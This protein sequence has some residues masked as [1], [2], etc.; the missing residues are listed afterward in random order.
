LPSVFTTNILY[1]FPFSPIRAT[2]PA[3]LMDIYMNLFCVY[4]LCVIIIFLSL[5]L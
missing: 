3:N 2:C 5:L 4:V 1:S